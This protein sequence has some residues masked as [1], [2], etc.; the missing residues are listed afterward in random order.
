MGALGWFILVVIVLAI[1]IVLAA[2]WYER[3]ANEVCLVPDRHWWE[4]GCH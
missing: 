4:A 1:L 2:W 3:A